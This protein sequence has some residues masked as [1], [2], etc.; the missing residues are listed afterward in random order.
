MP[1]VPASASEH[2]ATWKFDYPVYH[3]A[4]LAAW[5]AWLVAHHDD[6]RVAR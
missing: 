1:K 2:P 3:P 6:T 4:D 5:R